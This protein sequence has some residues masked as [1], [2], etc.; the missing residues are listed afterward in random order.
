MYSH[1]V[2]THQGYTGAL[3]STFIQGTPFTSETFIHVRWAWLSLLIGLAALSLVFLLATIVETNL[4]NVEAMRSD[5]LAGVTIL[6]AEAKTYMG[7]AAPQKWTASRAER[8]MVRLG[9]REGGWSLR[10]VGEG[11]RGYRDT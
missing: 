1:R 11:E 9:R 8:L 5:P 3:N 4:A 6:D 7:A 10:P 2:R